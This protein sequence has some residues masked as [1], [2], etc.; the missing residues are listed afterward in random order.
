[1]DK[2]DPAILNWVALCGG[3]ISIEDNSD[4][5]FMIIVISGSS[6]SFFVHRDYQHIKET[7]L[8]QQLR[9]IWMP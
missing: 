3:S 1:M 4:G 2:I 8:A 5:L 7:L 9:D 6:H